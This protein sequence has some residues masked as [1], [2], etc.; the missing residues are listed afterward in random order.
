MLVIDQRAAHERVL[1]ES[2][3][4][5]L[6]Q[7][8]TAVQK[9]LWPETIQCNSAD[10]LLLRELIPYLQSLGFDI[11]EFGHDTFI[12]HGIPAVMTDLIPPQQAIEDILDRYK[13]GHNLAEMK[14]VEKIAFALASNLSRRR[15]E[16][17]TT[18]EMQSLL[19][20]LMASENP[21][22]SPSGRKTFISFGKEEI[23]KRF[24]S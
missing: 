1:F 13:E 16:I 12:I 3:M 7:Q 18:E 14:P 9:L 4:E 24:Q 19:E 15:G 10:A 8:R 20:K 22:K 17:M 23:L 6:T 2:L 21:Y 11:S 5:D